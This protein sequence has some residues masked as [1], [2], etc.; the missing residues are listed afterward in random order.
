MKVGPRYKVCKRLGNGVFEKCQTQKYALSEGKKTFSAG[1]RPRQLSDYGKQL[2]EKQR[3]RYTY[4]ITEKQLTKYVKEA[5]AK[6][7]EATEAILSTLERR[8]DNI[9]YRIGLAPTRRAARQM[10]VHGHILVNGKKA[11]IPSHIIKQ[12]DVITVKE[13]SKNTSLFAD[14]TDRQ[15][16]MRTPTW[17][18]FNVK[19]MEGVVKNM[20]NKD[21]TETMF[22]LGVVMEYYSR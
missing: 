5:V 17:L 2:L 14:L 1:R 19:K 9:V 21:N 13:S 12:D 16:D 6:D 20:P 15:S 3:V 10:V 4:G 22:D 8:L 11:A 7:G 18:T